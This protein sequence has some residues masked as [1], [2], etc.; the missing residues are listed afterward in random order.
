MPILQ[1][2]PQLKKL[3]PDM[4]E[5]FIGMACAVLIVIAENTLNASVHDSP[6]EGKSDRLR[7][8]SYQK[9]SKIIYVLIRLN[10]EIYDRLI[11]GSINEDRK[12]CDRYGN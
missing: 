10:L 3:Y 8:R 2:L 5:I 4:Y 7:I 9:R 12:Y 6:T 1:D 11:T